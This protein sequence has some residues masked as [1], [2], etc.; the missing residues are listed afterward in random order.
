[1][2]QPCNRSL[3]EKDRTRTVEI[4][5]AVV[6]VGTQSMGEV[7]TSQQGSGFRLVQCTSLEGLAAAALLL[8]LSRC[9]GGGRRTHS[10]R[11][12]QTILDCP[13]DLPGYAR[14]DGRESDLC[15]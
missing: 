5:V 11:C 6:V 2:G 7:R 3:W 14:H 12:C 9:A 4:A 1:M 10:P 13:L 8:L 15:R